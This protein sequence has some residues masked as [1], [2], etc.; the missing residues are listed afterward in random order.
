[1]TD[2]DTIGKAFA[3]AAVEQAQ[4]LA[5]HTAPR[6]AS[7]AASGIK[8]YERK[9]GTR[10]TT[11]VTTSHGRTVPLSDLIFGAEFGS[12][13]LPQFPNRKPGG[14]WLFP[15]GKDPATYEQVMT[16]VVDQEIARAT[17]P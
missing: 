8:A 4:E 17:A 15:A 14:Y 2:G 10:G 6:Q 12:S 11:R 1:M 5:P 9:Y 13:R 3:K 16:E 7:L